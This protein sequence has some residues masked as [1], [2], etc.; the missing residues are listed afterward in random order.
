MLKIALIEDEPE[1]CAAAEQALRQWSEESGEEIETESYPSARAFF[2]DYDEGRV[3]DVLVVDIELESASAG[4][5]LARTVR[6]RDQYVSIF[7]LTHLDDVYQD[8]F[9]VSALQYLIKPLKYAQ[10]R[11]CLER[12]MQQKRFVEDTTYMLNQGKGNQQRIFCSE[13]LYFEAIEQHV[14][15]HMTNGTAYKE[16]IR[17]KDVEKQLPKEFVRIHRKYIVNVRHVTRIEPRWVTVGGKKLSVSR[18]HLEE[19]RRA[20]SSLL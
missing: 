16:W 19:V 10:L 13:I 2:F 8:A 15:I 20:W 14:V 4:M 6:S 18:G 1:D 5:D 12:T 9:E 17:L 3:F 11:R 7:F